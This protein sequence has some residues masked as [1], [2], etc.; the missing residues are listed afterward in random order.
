MRH[1]WSVNVQFG[2]H[3]ACWRYPLFLYSR[4][5][6]PSC[7]FFYLFLSSDIIVFLLFEYYNILTMFV[8]FHFVDEK[9]IEAA[10]SDKLFVYICN[11]HFWGSSCTNSEIFLHL[12]LFS[13]LQV[14]IPSSGFLILTSSSYVWVYVHTRIVMSSSYTLMSSSVN[15]FFNKH[16]HF[17]NE[18]LTC[19]SFDQFNNLKCFCFLARR[20]F[21]F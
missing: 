15:V 18:E 9:D 13:S 7:L 1:N 19:R 2:W 3:G 12:N 8:H 20:K 5:S 16:F 10:L 11:Y 14:L 21:Y 4:N 17:E 6:V